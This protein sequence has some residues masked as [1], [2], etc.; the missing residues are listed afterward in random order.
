LAKFSGALW[1]YGVRSIDALLDLEPVDCDE[2]GLSPFQLRTIRNLANEKGSGGGN[3]G[4][5]GGGNG[6]GSDLGLYSN[7]GAGDDHGAVLSGAGDGNDL[8]KKTKK[9]EG[10]PK[11]NIKF[12]STHVVIDGRGCL[13][14]KGDKGFSAAAFSASLNHL[15][16]AAGAQAKMVRLAF[17]IYFCSRLNFAC[18][19]IF[20]RQTKIVCVAIFEPLNEFHPCTAVTEALRVDPG[21]DFIVP[22][23]KPGGDDVLIKDKLRELAIEFCDEPS[24]ACVVLVANDKDFAPE[25]C[26]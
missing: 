21:I 4:G 10:T 24:K 16:L 18:L 14:G 17:P 5:N 1:N 9:H 19:S 13:V 25:V 15:L 20:A 22:M 26:V 2:L 3:D 8:D 7:G 11:A 12:A 23:K 6:G